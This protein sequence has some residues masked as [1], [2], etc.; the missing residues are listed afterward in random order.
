MR[1]IHDVS[2]AC[3]ADR[4]TAAQSFTWPPVE[5]VDQISSCSSCILLDD[6][7]FNTTICHVHSLTDLLACK[8]PQ[9]SASLNGLHQLLEARVNTFSKLCMLQGKLD[10]MIAQGELKESTHKTQQ[11]AAGGL[12]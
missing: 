11:L 10:L 3:T 4:A 5:C 9:L 8:V 12:G 1:L 2:L 6:S 7:M